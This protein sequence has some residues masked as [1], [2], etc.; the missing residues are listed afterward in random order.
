MFQ[1]KTK[2]VVLGG[3]TAGWLSALFIQR[4]YQN[5]EIS[6]I[7]D[8][9]RPPIIAGESGTT[10][11]TDFL[12]HLKIDKEDFIKKVNATPKLGGNFVDWNGVGTKFTHCLQTD[13]SPWLD[14]WSNY[15]KT[16]DAEE[17]TLSGSQSLMLSE[18]GKQLYMKSLI[19]GDTPLEY[20]FYS[21]EFIRQ[22]KVPFG[23]YSDIPCVPMWHFESRAA[24]AYF[25]NT[26]LS[27][28]INLIEGKFNRASQVP[29]GDIDKLYLEDGRIIEGDWFI[30]C[31]GFAR[32]LLSKT[33][34]EPLIDYSKIFTANSVVAWWDKPQYSVTTNAT[35]MKYGWSWNINLR[36]RSGNGYIYNSSML[37]LDQA[38][39]EAE[40]RFNKKIEPIANF[41]YTPGVMKNSWKY[42]VFGIGLSSGF[43]EPLEANGVAVI[44]ESL[45][46]LSDYWAPVGE[47]SELK[48]NKF[49]LRTFSIT[50]DIKDF[51]ALHFRGHRDDSEFWIDHRNNIER[52]P[53]SLKHKLSQ[54]ELFY[55]NE[56]DMPRFNGYSSSAW[57]TV[58]Q[59]L[60]VFD[61][62][63][64]KDRLKR[65]LNLSQKVLNTTKSKHME[66]VAP[67]WT[68]DQWISNT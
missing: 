13:F 27:R 23:A 38:V 28:N 9:D 42:N 22:N 56:S 15:I 29:N 58:L 51:L 53:D 1:K 66:T 18:H 60:D 40:K 52:I 2:I 17:L 6:V 32:L 47:N 48:R 37:T 20:L 46:A 14:D 59:G 10:T 16:A 33:L 5:V 43:L 49:N 11:F 45:Y 65:T 67:F 39:E 19:A 12:L 26:G 63:V 25:K 62:S 57:L 4:N 68:I 8:P 24:A 54:W 30:D 50:E 3:G 64:L 55:K 21:G 41:T 31:S 36:H 61:N 34:E 7:E 44:V 35:A